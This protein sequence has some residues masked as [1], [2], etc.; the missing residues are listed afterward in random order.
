M[1]LQ[2]GATIEQGLDRYQLES[3]SIIHGGSE[4]WRSSHVRPPTS[5]TRIASS[6]GC[7]AETPQK[8]FWCDLV[9][10]FG[11][12]TV[13]IQYEVLAEVSYR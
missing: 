9:F 2:V 5:L 1:R 6:V 8:S 7:S 12:G 4:A 3:I 11:W 13:Q 10:F